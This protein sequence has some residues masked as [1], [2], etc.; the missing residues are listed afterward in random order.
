MR[1]PAIGEKGVVDMNGRTGLKIRQLVTKLMMNG[2]QLA[3]EHY[4]IEE[5][6][7]WQ[8]VVS[9]RDFKP[10]LRTFEDQTAA[11]KEDSKMKPLLTAINNACAMQGHGTQYK[12]LLR[13][14]ISL[15]AGPSSG[16]ARGGVRTVITGSTL[17]TVPAMGLFLQYSSICRSTGQA[18]DRCSG[19]GRIHLMSAA[20]QLI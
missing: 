3:S 5:E 2:V 13:Q 18:G 15:L 9:H 10:L 8:G 4:G 16:L 14:L 19:N 6:A 1:H 11:L 17:S 7:M 20:S 12:R